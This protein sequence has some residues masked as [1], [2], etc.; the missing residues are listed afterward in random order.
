MKTNETC[1]EK[2]NRER[3]ERMEFYKKNPILAE[4]FE[5]HNNFMEESYTCP[6]TGYKMSL[7]G[8]IL[9]ENN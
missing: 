4:E 9:D 8:E 1:W 7:T 5:S 2:S 3:K 6:M